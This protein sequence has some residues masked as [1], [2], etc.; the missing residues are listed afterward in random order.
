MEYKKRIIFVKKIQFLACT[1]KLDCDLI[2]NFMCLA[3]SDK[4]LLQIISSS[5]IFC[6]WIKYWGRRSIL[7]TWV[8]LIIS[9]NLALGITPQV[10]SR[11]RQSLSADEYHCPLCRQLANVLLP[12]LPTG[13]EAPVLVVPQS[14]N[15]L[16][17][18]ELG[19]ILQQKPSKWVSLFSAIIRACLW[20]SIQY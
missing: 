9:Y 20:Y 5:N 12:I 10:Q 4:I 7:L 2:L 15:L 14:D 19:A 17:I 3:S 16:C 1:T 13:S 18:K 8:D 11:Q 6:L